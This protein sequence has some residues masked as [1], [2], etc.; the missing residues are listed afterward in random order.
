MTTSTPTSSNEPIRP[1]VAAASVT[2][3]TPSGNEAQAWKGR[4]SET[5]DVPKTLR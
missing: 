4:S 5:I 2:N 3:V 1:G